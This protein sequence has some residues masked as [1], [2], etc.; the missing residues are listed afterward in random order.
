VE[1]GGVPGGLIR[2]RIAPSEL[3]GEGRQLGVFGNEA[4]LIE[5][6]RAFA[7]T[8]ALLGPDDVL[9]AQ[10]QGGRMPAQ[11][12]SWSRWNEPTNEP[13]RD[14][15][16]PWP[17][18][19]PKPSPSLVPPRLQPLQVEWD[20]GLPSRVRLGT[21]WEP[22]L[23][24]S[25]PWRLSGRWWAGER[26]ADRYQLVTSACALLCVVADGKSYLAGVYD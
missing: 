8:Q 6:E 9:Q 21:R 25:G 4:A 22:V 13:E 7:R 19:T 20:N 1:N 23:T 11:R 2:I 10:P 18:S 3:S 15:D 16:A 26:D 12:V 5:A 24:W 17:G 14:S